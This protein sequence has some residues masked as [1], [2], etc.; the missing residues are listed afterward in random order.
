ME[1]KSIC[2]K[3]A[4]R[5]LEQI[6]NKCKFSKK[7]EKKSG[8]ILV[9]G[10]KSKLVE[11]DTL[12]EGGL[13]YSLSKDTKEVYINSDNPAKWIYS[14]EDVEILQASQGKYSVVVIN[15]GENSQEGL[16]LDE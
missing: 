7:A 11:L 8:Y 6:F 4:V 1:I 13:T 2:E 10:K 16:V 12:K 14:N 5:N 3:E 9:G 15:S